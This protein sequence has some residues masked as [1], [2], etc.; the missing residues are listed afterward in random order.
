MKNRKFGYFFA[1]MLIAAL[2]AGCSDPCKKLSCVSGTC[3]DGTCTCDP[4]YEGA[5]CASAF[6]KK[7]GGAYTLTESCTISGAAVPYSV[8]AR[9]KTGTT[10]EVIIVGLWEVPITEVT[11]VLTAD[12]KGFTIARQTLSTSS[13]KDV[14]CSNGTISADGKTINMTYKLYDTNGTSIVDECPA[15]L[16]R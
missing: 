13:H 6:N 11:A 8:S 12:G 3:L 4:G 2:M 15:T 1:F 5:D 7:F 9:A 10:T 14:S 16:R